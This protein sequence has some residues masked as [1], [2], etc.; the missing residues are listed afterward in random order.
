MKRI[1]VKIGS[2]VIAPKG[3]VNEAFFHRF[4]D[5]VDSVLKKHI[6][7]IVVSSGAIASGIKTAGLSS[8][9]SKV[10]DLQA[11]ASVGQIVLMNHFLKAFGSYKRTC[12]QLLLTWEDFEERDRY[13]NVRRT[14]LRLLEQG[15][16]PVINENDA[17]STEEIKFGDNDK[18]S[19]LVANLVEADMLI[20]L[21]D[22]KGLCSGTAL[23][24]NV[25]D[26][27]KEAMPHLKPYAQGSFTRG[28]MRSKLDAARIT[29][30]AGIPAVIASGHDKSI[31]RRIVEGKEPDCTVFCAK[32]KGVGARKRWIAFG[33]KERGTIVVD[34]GAEKALVY[35]GKSL[36]LP[37][38]RSIEGTFRKGDAVAIL[39]EQQERIAKGIAGYGAEQLRQKRDVR[40]E[41]VHRDSMV[42]LN[43]Q[44]DGLC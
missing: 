44:G 40:N 10:E 31:V 30:S 35:R 7:V 33:K 23:I 28:G 12:A 34:A 32:P 39:N 22:V 8:R 26:I 21:S 18:L 24:R 36:L 13:L 9:P 42:V 4:I 15:I 41:V 14:L 1:V 6:Q 16:V 3:H 37:G 11:L 19:A 25:L 2:S 17:V 5:D 27:D 43:K 20:I 29:T 38:I